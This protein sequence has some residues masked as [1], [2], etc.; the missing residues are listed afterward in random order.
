MPVPSSRLLSSSLSSYPCHHFRG[1][2]FPRLQIQIINP[3]SREQS[4]WCMQSMPKTGKEPPT[5]Q[6]HRVPWL[7]SLTTKV[8]Q[9][10]VSIHVEG[11]PWA[12]HTSKL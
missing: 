8:H 6:V 11:R 3:T 5:C 1:Q 10:E 12:K 4:P 7:V 2:G 9:R